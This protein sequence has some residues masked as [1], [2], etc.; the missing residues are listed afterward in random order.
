MM[1]GNR[2]SWLYT[3]FGPDGRLRLQRLR[4]VAPRDVPPGLRGSAWL[5][6]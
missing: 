5:F 1:R 6:A 3:Y 2:S 4:G